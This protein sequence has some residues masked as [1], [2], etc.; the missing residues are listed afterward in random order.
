MRIPSELEGLPRVLGGSVV[1][2]GEEGWDGAR[3]AWN[4]AVDQHPAAVAYAESADDVAR[5]V[6]YAREH[7]LGVAVQG[8]GHGAGTLGPLEDTLLLKTA[9]MKGIEIDAGARRARVEAGVVAADVA[10]RAGEAG[11]AALLGSSPDTG[12]TGF[13]LGGG[14]G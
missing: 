11:L 9:R 4:L 14:V 8:T 6:D 2:P 7:G 3:Q 5:A 12:V 1:L 10:L 13:T